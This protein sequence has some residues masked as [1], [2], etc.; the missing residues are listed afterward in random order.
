[1][2]YSIKAIRD[3]EMKLVGFSGITH[4]ITERKNVEIALLE[5]EHRMADII[6]FLPIASFVIDGKGVVTAWNKAME[7]LTGI[8]GK[9]MVGK[10]NYEYALPFYGK[11]IPILID[12]VKFSE[13]KMHK[14]YKHIRRTGD[15]LSAES[16]CEKL[17]EKGKMLVG[18][19]CPLYGSD[20]KVR[21][22]MNP[23]RMYPICARLKETARSQRSSKQPINQK[24]LFWR[25]C[26]M[27]FRTPMNAILDSRN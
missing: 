22:A 27:K 7:E 17:G 11:R 13:K 10:G 15:I 25:T 6:N 3:E 2:E 23:S 1:V 24:A 8:T 19:A 5:S 20:G 12:L 18:F 4:E 21:G 26:L 14:R 16:F 9:Q